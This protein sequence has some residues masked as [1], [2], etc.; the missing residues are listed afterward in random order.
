M[1]SGVALDRVD[2]LGQVGRGGDVAEAPTSHGVRLT[3][4]V[5]GEGEVV[6]VLAEGGQGG[7]LGVVID[8]LFVNFDKS[9]FNSVSAIV[10]F[11][12]SYLHNY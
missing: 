9:D 7:V 11:P 10:Y 8:E 6:D 1:G 2:R 12:I 5:D 3:E 4:T